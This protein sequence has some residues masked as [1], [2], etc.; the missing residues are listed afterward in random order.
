MSVSPLSPFRSIAQR[1]REGSCTDPKT[2]FKVIEENN[3]VL[4]ATTA[5][6][7]KEIEGDPSGVVLL[8]IGQIRSEIVA[9]LEEV[10]TSARADLKRHLAV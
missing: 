5:T 10:T 7:L 4:L 6:T 3:F 8:G 1:A 2:L 9:A